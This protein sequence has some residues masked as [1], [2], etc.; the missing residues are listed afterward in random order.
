MLTSRSN[1]LTPGALQIQTRTVRAGS[2]RYDVRLELADERRQL[3]IVNH[4]R[5]A[6]MTEDIVDLGGIE[7]RVEH[8]EDAAGERHREG[9]FERA[10]HVGREHGD[11]LALLNTACLQRRS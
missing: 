7:A 5:R 3:G 6:A 11:A 4:Q 10:R 1:G 9:R 8:A 2:D